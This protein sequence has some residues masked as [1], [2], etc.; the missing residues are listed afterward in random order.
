MFFLYEDK[1]NP[2]KVRQCDLILNY[3]GFFFIKPPS[4]TLLLRGFGAGVLLK[5]NF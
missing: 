1:K 3:T 2:S 4:F 5:Y